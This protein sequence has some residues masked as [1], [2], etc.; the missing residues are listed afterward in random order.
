MGENETGSLDRT[1]EGRGSGR[2]TLQ[3]IPRVG[4]VETLIDERRIRYDVFQDG[5]MKRRP[6]GE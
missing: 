1:R 2:E 4:Q 3:I 6:V 5:V